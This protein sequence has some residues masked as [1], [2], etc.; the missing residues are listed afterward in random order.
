MSS[1]SSKAVRPAVVWFRGSDLRIHDHEPLLEAAKA[2][3]GHVVPVYCFD[4]RQVGPAAKTRCGQF[5]KCGWQRTRFIVECVEDLR[6]NLQRLG[7]NL[8]VRVGEPEEVI[9]DIVSITGATEVFGQKEVCSEETGVEHRLAKRLSVPLTLRWGAIT[10]CHRDD[11]PYE[12]SCSD[13]PGVFSQFRKAA[14]ACVPIRPPRPPPPSLQPLPQPIAGDPGH[15]PPVTQLSPNAPAKADER[16]VL[17]FVGGETVARTRV[18]HYLW[19]TDC[20]ATYKDTRNGLVGADY[21]SKFSP[22]LAHGC[23]SARWIH[24]EVKRYERERVKNN[25]TYWLVFELLWR[26]YFRFVALQ[27]GTA[28]FKEGGVQRK[29]IAWR[30]SPLDLSAWQEGR[31]GF[32]FVDANMRELAATGFMSNRGRQNVASFLT[33]DL[34]IDWRLGAEWFESLLIDHDPCANYGN[35]NYA[36]GIGNDPRQGRHFNVIRQAKTYDPAAEYVHLWVPELKHLPAPFA[37][38]PYQAPHGELEAA[39]VALEKSYP[40]PIVASLDNGRIPIRGGAAKMYSA[41]KPFKGPKWMDR[42]GQEAGSNTSDGG[43]RSR[44]GKRRGRHN[45]KPRVQGGWS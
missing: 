15:V 26:D 11:L 16:G 10:L 17:T 7:S 3:K 40:R 23:V 31:T 36:A 39:G 14:E 45:R 5:P 43:G 30:H 25:S 13:L 27:H 34:L 42:D 12:R 21:S 44:S 32:P 41:G 18:K 29:G 22:W 19:D 35:W 6:R 20:I 38:T 8:V 37:H 24:S 28:I 9:P 33:K 4:P 2:S 1:S